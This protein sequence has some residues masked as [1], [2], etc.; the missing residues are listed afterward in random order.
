MSTFRIARDELTRVFSPRAAKAF[1]QMQDTVVSQGETI[2]SGIAGTQSLREAT[3]LT[4]SPNAELPN[5][6]VLTL[7][8]GLRFETSAGEVAIHSDAPQVE[9]GHRVRFVVPGDATIVLP[10]VGVVATREGTET[11]ANKTLKAPAL[12][13]LVN[14]LNDAAAAA[15]G[16]AVGGMY[17]NGSALMVRVA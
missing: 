5:E 12:D 3:F 2:G 6:Y 13:G 15:G 7:G 11:L 14:A 4:L 1:E 10:I 16:V 17:R 9:G 8:P